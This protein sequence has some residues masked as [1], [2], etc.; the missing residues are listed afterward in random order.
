MWISNTATTLMLL[1]V[2]LAVLEQD[3]ASG[4]GGTLDLPLLLGIAYAASIGGMGTPVGTPPNVIFMAV[5][6]E[7]TGNKIAFID[8]MMIGLP[9]VILLIPVA[10]LM[11]T[12]K[13]KSSNKL[14]LPDLGPW[15]SPEKRVLVIF[16]LDAGGMAWRKIDGVAFQHAR[17]SVSLK[18]LAGKGQTGWNW[19]KMKIIFWKIT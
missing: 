12:R 9:A 17:H 5:Y 8:W 16:G 13:L 11:V 14:D 4:G 15:S 2:A 10:W 19:M 1:P 18:S 3:R 7:T 6:E